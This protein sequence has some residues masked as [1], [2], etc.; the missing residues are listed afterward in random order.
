MDASLLASLAQYFNPSELKVVG[1]KNM[2]ILG[3]ERE[4]IALVELVVFLEGQHLDVDALVC[5]RVW[6]KGS[7][8]CLRRGYTPVEL[9]EFLQSLKKCVYDSSFGVQELFG[10]LYF[11]DG[12]LAVRTVYDGSEWWT[13]KSAEWAVLHGRSFGR[14]PGENGEGIE[15]TD[16][17]YYSVESSGESEESDEVQ[18]SEVWSNLEDALRSPRKPRKSRKSR[19]SRESRGSRK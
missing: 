12:S 13:R 4:L 9:G 10:E 5:A 11:S 1:E 3:M 15:L 17:Q 7:H 14:V 18:A 19:K 2:H 8:M 6:T 16:S